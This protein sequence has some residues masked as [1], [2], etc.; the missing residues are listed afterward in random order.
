MG[1]LVGAQVVI[2]SRGSNRW[3]A[4]VDLSMMV[5]YRPGL[6]VSPIAISDDSTLSTLPHIQVDYLSHEWSEEDVWRS[7]GS[8]RRQKDEIKDGM[9]LENASWRTWWKHRNKLTTVAPENLN[10]CISLDLFC[11]KNPYG[12]QDERQ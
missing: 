2:S 7:W 3:V 10:W 1:D 12:V 8:M 6:L 4:A 11:R 5:H 9:R